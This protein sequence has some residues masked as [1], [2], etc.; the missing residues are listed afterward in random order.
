MAVLEL[1]LRVHVHVEWTWAFRQAA[2]TN[3]EAFFRDASCFPR[4]TWLYLFQSRFYTCTRM[5]VWWVLIPLP[6]VQCRMAF[7]FNDITVMYSRLMYVFGWQWN[8]NQ[9]T[10]SLEMH[11]HVHVHVH[12]IDLYH[13]TAILLFFTKPCDKSESGRRNSL[14]P[15]MYW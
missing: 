12:V 3:R 9:T 6:E 2:R 4:K 14:V 7:G 1:L 10:F 11:G 8:H 5:H 15:F 13:C